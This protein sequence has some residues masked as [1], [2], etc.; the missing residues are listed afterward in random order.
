MNVAYRPQTRTVKFVYVV[1][2]QNIAE[3]RE[4]EIGKSIKGQRIVTSGLNI[5]ELIITEG[6]IRIQPG[7]PVIPQT[8]DQL[9]GFS[10]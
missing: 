1:N 10:N 5:G 8:K 3:Y 7:M 2:E 4:I 6:I 9:L